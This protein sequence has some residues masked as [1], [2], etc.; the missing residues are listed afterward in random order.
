MGSI[1]WDKSLEFGIDEIDTQH[2]NFVQS[3]NTLLEALAKGQDQAAIRAEF[4]S[5]R[6]YSHNHFNSEER[7]MEESKFPDMMEHKREH[8]KF[9]L[10]VKQFGNLVYVGHYV[11]AS[12]VIEFLGKWLLEHLLGFDAKL[13]DHLKAQ[14]QEAPIR[15]EVLARA[16]IPVRIAR[17]AEATRLL[18]DDRDAPARIDKSAVTPRLA[19]DH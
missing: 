12:Q 16:E 11:R 13:R 2:I 14:P 18:I 9:R 6:D 7:L 1:K 8:D 15:E 3:I 5:L 17:P 10:Q 4:H 19:L